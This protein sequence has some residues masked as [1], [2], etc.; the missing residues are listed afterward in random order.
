MTATPTSSEENSSSANEKPER[1]L[2]SVSYMPDQGFMSLHE[3]I[4]RSTVIARATM[5]SASA[6]AQDGTTTP[7]TYSP[8]IQFT[9]DI[10]E[11]L[12]GND[13]NVI[14]ANI[15]IKCT[16]W[17]WEKCNSPEEQDVIDHANAWLSEETN[18][19]WETRESIIFLQEDNNRDSK[20]TGESSLP[21]YKFVPWLGE[22]ATTRQYPYS[23]NDGFSVL[24]DHNRV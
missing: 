18:R 16:E 14:A 3:R 19:W 7:K 21:S 12:K 11:Y 24:S 17:D 22:Y 2:S 4:L 15:S 6:Y 13:A 23:D 9:F 8:M 10:H 20:T 5:R 1:M